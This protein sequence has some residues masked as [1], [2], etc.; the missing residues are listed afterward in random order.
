MAAII[1]VHWIRAVK[2]DD[3]AMCRCDIFV[4]ISFVIINRTEPLKIRAKGYSMVSSAF[5]LSYISQA[6]SWKNRV[7]SSSGQSRAV[8]VIIRAMNSMTKVK[9]DHFPS[10][11]TPPPKLAAQIPCFFPFFFFFF[12]L[13]SQESIARDAPLHDALSSL[14]V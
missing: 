6:R 9:P 3:C 11:V 8:T 10:K 14:K 5:L 7:V 13:K 1:D 12:R 2:E 4:H